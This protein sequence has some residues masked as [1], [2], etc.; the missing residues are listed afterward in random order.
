MLI[1]RRFFSGFF[2]GAVFSF[3]FSLGFSPGICGAGQVQVKGGYAG[4]SVKQTNTSLPHT[5]HFVFK[6]KTE[7]QVY[8]KTSRHRAG[9]FFETISKPY[10]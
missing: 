6:Y 1:G 4:K 2:I 3:F 5:A 7:G 8:K 10:N 9:C